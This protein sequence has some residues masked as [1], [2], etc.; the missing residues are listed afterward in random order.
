MKAKVLMN[1]Y[2]HTGIPDGAESISFVLDE[3]DIDDSS[4]C[5]QKAKER[6]I[7]YGVKEESIQ[8]E[9]GYYYSDSFHIVCEIGR[10]DKTYANPVFMFTKECDVR[11]NF[12]YVIAIGKR[13]FRPEEIDIDVLL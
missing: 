4:L 5:M 13:I 8:K 10:F 3:F 6:L 12:S 7:E 2:W 9:K 1:V 11:V